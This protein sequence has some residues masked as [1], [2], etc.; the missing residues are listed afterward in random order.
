MISPEL[1]FKVPFWA[2]E[3]VGIVV[4][5]AIDFLMAYVYEVL[6]KKV[7]TALRKRLKTENVEEDEEEENPFDYNE[8][9]VFDHDEVK[10]TDEAKPAESTPEVNVDDNKDDDEDFFK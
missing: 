2:V 6:K 8:N 10:E 1:T 5:M 4:L 3:L 7:S 9:S